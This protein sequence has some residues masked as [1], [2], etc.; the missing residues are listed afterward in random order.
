MAKIQ[1]KQYLPTI[2]KDLYHQQQN[3]LEIYFRILQNNLF[4]Q[5]S[6]V[7]LDHYINLIYK[8][9][10]ARYLVSKGVGVDWN[11]YFADRGVM[12]PFNLN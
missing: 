6:G 7:T 2:T 4:L 1:E 5:E 11:G 8:D 9:I 12:N 10:Y 3:S